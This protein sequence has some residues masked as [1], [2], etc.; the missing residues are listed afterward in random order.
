[1]RITKYTYTD[2]IESY[3][4]E[5]VWRRVILT[6]YRVTS[7]T[8]LVTRLSPPR[9]HW[10]SSTETRRVVR[11]RPTLQRSHRRSLPWTG[12]PGRR[13]PSRGRRS[14]RRRRSACT[15][16]PPSAAAAATASSTAAEHHKR[17]LAAVC[18]SVRPSV[19][20]CERASDR[21]MWLSSATCG[22]PSS[23]VRTRSSR[24]ARI[25]HRR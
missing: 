11:R 2:E 9:K 12:S 1:M 18:A 19:R 25:T 10:H 15:R 23:D 21:S 7:Y 4:R 22:R 6:I 24:D 5:W 8:G 16:A 13:W 3:H 20:P 17:A 14:R